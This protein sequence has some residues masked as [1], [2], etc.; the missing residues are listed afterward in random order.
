MAGVEVAAEMVE[1][2]AVAVMESR[3][4]ATA[5]EMATAVQHHHFDALLVMPVVYI[6]QRLRLR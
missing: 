4:L 2:V 1:E 6:L 5:N 3:L